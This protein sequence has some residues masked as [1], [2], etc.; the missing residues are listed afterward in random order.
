[1]NHKIRILVVVAALAC[2]SHILSAQT[3]QTLYNFTGYGDGGNPLSSLVMDAAG[4]LYGTTFVGGQFGAGEVFEL[5]PTGISVLYSFTG[6]AD[7]ANPYMADVIFDA[8]GNLYG[9][10]VGGGANDL[11][12]IFKLTPSGSGWSES[13]LHSFQGQT[14]GANPY[15]GLVFD[16]AG[17]L[18]GTT[19]L[20]G[21][22]NQGTI[23]QLK[24][25]ANS[26]W[27]EEVVHTFGGKDGSVPAGGL[28]FDRKN[29]LYGVTQGGGAKAAGVV[30]RLSPSAKGWSLAVL[31]SFTGGADGSNPY[32]ER[33]ILDSTGRVYGTTEGGGLAQSGTVFR[34]T[35]AATGQWS[36]RVLYSF[37]SKVAGNPFSGLVMDTK[38]NLYGTCANGNSTTTVGAVFELKVQPGDKWTE[39]NLHLF[40]RTDGEFPEAALLR[41]A[42]GNLYGTTLLGGANN[43]GVVF[44]IVR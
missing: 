5:S 22:N 2:F 15:A 19:A 38:G 9:T 11:G 37:N 14:D 44:E 42:S 1:M 21:I 6:G 32:G 24:P 33:L 16:S 28:V 17:N 10:T 4:N 8:S 23:F 40:T 26:Q 20:G 41:D 29:N 36:E 3:D 39:I 35:P 7:G 31:H 34:L 12:T 30:Y 13:V 43:M 27:I 25:A 18:Y